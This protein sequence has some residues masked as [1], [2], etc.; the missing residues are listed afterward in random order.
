MYPSGEADRAAEI[1]RASWLSDFE[2]KLHRGEAS[3]RDI[4]DAYQAGTAEALAVELS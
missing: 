2:I 3:Y 1:S 4:E